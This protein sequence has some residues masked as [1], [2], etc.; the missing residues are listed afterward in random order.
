[1]QIF[2]WRSNARRSIGA[3]DFNR[4]SLHIKT[5][6]SPLLLGTALLFGNAA[7]A[8]VGVTERE[9]V[10]GQSTAL[11]GPLAPVGL[12]FSGAAKAYF[13]KINNDGGIHGRSIRLTT[14]DDA[15]VADKTAKNV[16]QLIEQEKVFALFGL[17]GVAN[18]AVA[19]PIAT[20]ARIPLLFPMNGEPTLRKVPNRYMFTLTAGF[21]DEI[22]KIVDHLFTIGV[23]RIA[24]AHFSNPF[25]NAIKAAAE[26]ALEKKSLK[27]T[28]SVSFDISGSTTLAAATQ[29]SKIAPDAIIVGA[30]AAGAADFI[31]AYKKTGVNAQ[32]LTFSGV[33]TDVLVKKLGPASAGIVV[34]QVVPYPWAPTNPLV[35]DYQALM[36]AG[37]RQ[38]VSYLGMWG[39]I[40]ARTTVEALRKTGKDLTREKLVTT[41]EGMRGL[42]LNRYLLDFS[43]SN[44]HGSRFVDITMIGPNGKLLK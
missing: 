42:D 44:H 8:E 29:L 21:D 3:R 6:I 14:V 39:Y 16:T 31:S 41:L 30:V 13:E 34:S 25:G 32:F 17:L 43:P 23:K 10:L 27:L 15:Y 33:G 5:C 20:E 4:L 38:E 11:T 36:K 37:G 1:M 12:E 2:F 7:F 40:S 19:L 22:S 9:I 35:R 24:V 18:T 28:A 26:Q